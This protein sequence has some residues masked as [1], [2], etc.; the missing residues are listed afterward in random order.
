MY[1]VMLP[2]VSVISWALCHI[3]LMWVGRSPRCGGLMGNVHK[4]GSRDALG[5]LL[6][7][8]CVGHPASTQFELDIVDHW[9]VSWPR[10]QQF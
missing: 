10:P 2:Y 1:I 4:C 8:L 5:A 3:I 9:E 7:I 6:S